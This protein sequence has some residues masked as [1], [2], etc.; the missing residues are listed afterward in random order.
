MTDEQAAALERLDAEDGYIGE[1]Q[2]YNVLAYS[3]SLNR[4]ILVDEE[5]EVWYVPRWALYIPEEGLYV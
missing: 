5:G 4:T 1:D 2:D 3:D